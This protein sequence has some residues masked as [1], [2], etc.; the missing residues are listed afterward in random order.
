MTVGNWGDGVGA[1]AAHSRQGVKGEAG[2]GTLFATPNPTVIPR[3]PR[4]GH[5]GD[6]C[7]PVDGLAEVPRI[8]ALPRPWD[9]GWEVG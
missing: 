9:D 7:F 3:W 1:D 4:S 2:A 6:L 8:A 5:P